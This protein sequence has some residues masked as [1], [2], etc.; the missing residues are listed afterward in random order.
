MSNGKLY[1]ARLA[2]GIM[3][4]FSVPEQAIVKLVERMIH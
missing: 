4:S 3:S 1:H 2:V